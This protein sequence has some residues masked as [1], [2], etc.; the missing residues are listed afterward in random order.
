M[1]NNRAARDGFDFARASA[2][3]GF[4]S[5]I[6]EFVRH[7]FLERNGKSY[8]ATP[9]SRIKVRENPKA[10]LIGDLD[11]HGWLTRARRACRDKMAAASFTSA[12]RAFDEALFRMTAETSRHAIQETLIALGAFLLE[13]ARRP[14]L[15]ENLPPP[16]PLSM[17]WVKEADDGSS[18][19]ALASSLA[20][21][22]AAAGDFRLPFRRHLAPLGQQGW[23][24]MTEAVSLTVWNGR[25]PVR[26]M[27]SVLER[28]MI[29]TKRHDF[30][31]I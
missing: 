15:R 7:G 3:L 20:S 24:D 18:E 8:F 31:E 11:R 4:A 1:V 10:S 19:F 25:N 17:R 21:L 5:G 14:K 16:P 22:D 26:D 13:V 9:L 29:E 30:Q 6:D 2:Q 27:A 28:R 12:G 23:S